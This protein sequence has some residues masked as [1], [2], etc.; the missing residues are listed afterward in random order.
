MS[1]PVNCWKQTSV[2]GF[3]M[4][5]SLNTTLNTLAI[6]MNLEIFAPVWSL[7]KLLPHAWAGDA[8]LEK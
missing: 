2:D 7:Q 8:D 5:C 1:Y 6:E 3:C 4:D